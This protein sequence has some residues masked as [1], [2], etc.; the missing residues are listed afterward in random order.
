MRRSKPKMKRPEYDR[1]VFA[2]LHALRGH[3]NTEI[4]RHTYLS[5]STIAKIRKGPSHGG[6]RWP[7]HNTLT[8]LARIAGM[9]YQLA[10]DQ[11]LP[12]L[13]PEK[14]TEITKKIKNNKIP[15][16]AHAA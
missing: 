13:L 9:S 5:P 16:V 1:A 12:K 4:A 6:T 11:K 14:P 2:V 3:K 7:R 10:A 8:E 15:E